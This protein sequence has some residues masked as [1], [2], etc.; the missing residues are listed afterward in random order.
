[1]S[2]SG[3]PPSF[4]RSAIQLC[5]SSY[6]HHPLNQHLNQCSPHCAH[7]Q[8]GPTARNH[9]ETC[10]SLI[11]HTKLLEVYLSA[12]FGGPRIG[13]NGKI[14]DFKTSL[15]QTVRFSQVTMT[16]SL[17][18]G[19]AAIRVILRSG[20]NEQTPRHT[21]LQTRPVL[22]R[23]TRPAVS[24]SPDGPPPRPHHHRRDLD[25]DSA[26]AVAACQ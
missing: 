21:P 2:P 16:L 15:H 3:H 26:S 6:Y 20:R 7:Q 1:M 13:Q 24:G 25:S 14:Q 12:K 17:E 8:E 4:L 18:L 5:V 10:L 22:I 19:Y 23:P 11:G 9:I